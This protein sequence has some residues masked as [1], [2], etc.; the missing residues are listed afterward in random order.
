MKN[1]TTTRAVRLD[2]DPVLKYPDSHLGEQKRDYSE[3][4]SVFSVVRERFFT[5]K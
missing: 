4:Q 5:Q 2:D 1:G 3:T